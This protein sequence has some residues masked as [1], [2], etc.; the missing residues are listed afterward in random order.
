MSTMEKSAVGSA[1]LSEK[2]RGE[3]MPRER[4]ARCVAAALRDEEL[5]AV[6][7]GTGYRGRHVL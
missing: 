7:L 2:F 4:L 1:L 5:L 6:M 3:D